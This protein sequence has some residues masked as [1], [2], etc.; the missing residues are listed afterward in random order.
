MQIIIKKSRAAKI[1]AVATVFGDNNE[2]LSELIQN[3]FSR[4]QTA[5]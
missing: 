2:K 4:R 5:F 3:M 1:V